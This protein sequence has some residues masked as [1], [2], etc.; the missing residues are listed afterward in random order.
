MKTATA[1]RFVM[2]ATACGALSGCATVRIMT[3]KTVAN[4]L[5]APGDTYTSDDDPELV[6][7]AI[8]FGLKTFESLLESVPKHGP[9]LLATCS[10]FT[11]YAYA[12]VE[13]DAERLGQQD[14]EQA[15]LLKEEALKLYARGRSYCWRGLD[16]RFPRLSTGVKDDP[17]KA[18][19]AVRP[20]ASDVAL[21]YWSAASLGAAI[22]ID[23]GNTDLLA[24]LPIVRALAERALTLDETWGN[25]SLHELMIS[26]E[27]QGE[28]LGGSE[29]L[30]R[31]HFTRAVEL[32]RGL[33]AGPY[34]ALAMGVVRGRQDRAEFERLM[35]E[36]LAIDVNKTE[37]RSIRL[38]NIITQRRAR[39]LLDHVDDFFLK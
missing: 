35:T 33:S 19:A 11:S 34:V 23:K 39:W 8:P 7:K 9:L 30:A 18:L 24:D 27:S 20:K 22:S 1:L 2:L 38:L 10:G 3:V 29:D 4:A 15:K 37:N 6:R 25:G 12:F 14:Y 17:S 16:V 21:L 26:I 32:Q 28:A 31:T 5:A 36:A 13:A